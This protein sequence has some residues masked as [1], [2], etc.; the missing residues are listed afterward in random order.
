MSR[1]KQKKFYLDDQADS[2]NFFDFRHLSGSR[3][4]K[5]EKVKNGKKRNYLI[6]DGDKTKTFFGFFLSFLKRSKMVTQPKFKNNA[7]L[8]QFDAD[9]DGI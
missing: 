4:K 1:R 3:S 6:S 7:I 2:R 9:P 5:S 8:L